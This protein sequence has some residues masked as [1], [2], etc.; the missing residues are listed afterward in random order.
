MKLPDNVYNFLKWLLLIA[1][2][3][4]ITLFTFLAKTW[5]WDVPVD[6]IN[7]TICAVATFTG[8]LLG[9]SNHN[10]YKDQQWDDTIEE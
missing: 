6:S 7:G 5:S 1:V 8:V 4:F 9:I 10:Y 2:P 3:A